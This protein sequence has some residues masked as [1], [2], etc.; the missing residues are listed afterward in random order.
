MKAQVS[1]GA[2][3]EDIMSTL[4]KEKEVTKS[5]TVLLHI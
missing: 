1:K 2:K 3:K 5:T 4:N